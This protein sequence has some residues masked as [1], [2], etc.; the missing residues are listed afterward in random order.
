ML[1]IHPTVVLEVPSKA[2]GLVPT[3]LSRGSV[4][5]IHSSYTG[6]VE[7]DKISNESRYVRNGSNEMD[8]NKRV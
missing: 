6:W 5:R 4:K 7:N 1:A 3:F 2:K 8:S